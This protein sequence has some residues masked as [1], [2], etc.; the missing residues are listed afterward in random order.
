MFLF[1]L[2]CN[3]VDKIVKKCKI[4][5][6][7]DRVEE[8]DNMDKLNEILQEVGI[9][10]VKLAKYL[11]VSRQMIYNYLEM[12]DISRW[13]KDKKMKLF[14]L[15]DI[16]EAKEIDDI[17]VDTEFINKVDM[18]INGEVSNITVTHLESIEFKELKPREQELL[19][20]IIF[21]IKERFIENST[22]AYV[23]YKYLLNFVQGLENVKELKYM[24][25]Y[26]VKLLGF[27]NPEEFAFNEEEQFIFESIMHSAMVLYRNGGASKTKL[28]EQHKKFV[29]EIEHKNEEKLSRTQ[30][31][32]SAK[33][34]ALQELGYTEI[35]QSNASEVLAK[36]A[37][38]QS[39]DV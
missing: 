16:K 26:I 8:R 5:V 6:R 17:V 2:K 35:N 1:F 23:T 13:P 21:L 11:G 24:M 10:K 7:I 32:N 20:D 28:A 14:N 37:E 3:I 12:N 27:V 25:G 9:S 34:Q 30:E 38:I 36:I 19:N 4:I 39:R 31:I 18:V 33:I 29:A 15:L 22:D